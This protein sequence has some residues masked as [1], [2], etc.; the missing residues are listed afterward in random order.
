[1]GEQLKKMKDLVSSK[2]D[3]YKKA[4]TAKVNKY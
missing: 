1:M 4:Y 2:E 3:E